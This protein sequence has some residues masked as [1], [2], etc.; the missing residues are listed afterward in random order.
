MYV[1][2]TFEQTIFLELAISALEQLGI[3]QT[4]IL[5]VP[6]D[7]PKIDRQTFN[8]IHHPDGISLLD[9]AAVLGTVFMLLG[10]IYG[11]VLAWGPIIWGLIGGVG[12][13]LLGFIVK[14]LIVR[15]KL[16]KNGGYLRKITSEVVLMIV[17]DE[18]KWEE[19]EQALWAHTALG[20]S[21]LSLTR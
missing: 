15:K 9:L 18:S 3:A 16:M 12:G 1:V 5:A 14:Y 20:V 19:V 6:L 17:C 7:K 13:L 11:Y 21:R 4:D 10:A 2:A 8:S